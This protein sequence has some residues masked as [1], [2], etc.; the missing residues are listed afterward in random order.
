[1]VTPQE[2]TAASYEPIL[3]FRSSRRLMVFL[4]SSSLLVRS[5]IS[6]SIV[7]L[8]LSTLRNY[9]Q[10]RDMSA[11]QEETDQWGAWA[12]RRRSFIQIMWE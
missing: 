4:A 1:M 10:R 9:G 6:A 12:D 11:P 2:A 3:T 8:S 5:T 7:F